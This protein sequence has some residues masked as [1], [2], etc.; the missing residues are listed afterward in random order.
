MTERGAHRVDRGAD[1][2]AVGP[3][4]PAWDGDTLVIDIAEISAPLPYKVRGTVRVS[5]R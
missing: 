5:P 2:F 4:R 1:H 3:E